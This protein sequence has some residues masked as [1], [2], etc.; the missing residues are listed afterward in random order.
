MILAPVAQ[1]VNG[2]MMGLWDLRDLKAVQDIRV[3]L[4]ALVLLEMRVFRVTRASR[5]QLEKSDLLDLLVLPV[6]LDPRVLREKEDVEVDVER[7][8]TQ[9]R[10]APL[11]ALVQRASRACKAVKET[12]GCLVK[13]ATSVSPVQWVKLVL[14]VQPVNQAQLDSLVLQDHKVQR[15]TLVTLVQSVHLALMASLEMMVPKVR[16]ECVEK[17]VPL[18]M[19]DLL[20]RGDLQVPKEERAL[21]VQPDPLVNPGRW[22]LPVQRV[23]GAHV[24][25]RVQP[26]PP[27]RLVLRDPQ[28]LEATLV[29]PA[30]MENAVFRVL[31]VLRDLQVHLVM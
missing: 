2:A 15:V 31:Q 16:E 13:S 7:L 9:V 26:D 1:Q 19:L 3:F 11:A 28:D 27:E 24:V 30:S 21:L 22:A 6:K 20:D 8:V 14:R 5:V 10:S 18:A 29:P 4:E 25:A 23:R 12:V 17:L